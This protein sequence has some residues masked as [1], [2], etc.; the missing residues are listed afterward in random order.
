MTS[1]STCH[2]ETFLL[3]WAVR[4]TLTRSQNCDRSL[5]PVTGSPVVSLFETS[6]SL[7][8]SLPN[9][10]TFNLVPHGVVTP[11][12]KIILFLLHN[13]NFSTVMNHN[14]NI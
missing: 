9:A 14:V 13:C 8:L 7:V 11:N 1:P 4:G 6:V 5:K 10:V 12:H 2:E 3:L